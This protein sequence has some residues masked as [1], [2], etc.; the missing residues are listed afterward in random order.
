MGAGNLRHG[1]R[2]DSCGT[3]R[4]LTWQVQKVL[5]GRNKGFK[6]SMWSICLIWFLHQQR[7]ERTGWCP[8]RR[9]FNTNVLGSTV[10]IRNL[11]RALKRT[12][13]RH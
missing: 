3:C 13:S 11:T 12:R 6:V 1:G 7:G 4:L 10:P 9:A 5:L 8:S 2:N